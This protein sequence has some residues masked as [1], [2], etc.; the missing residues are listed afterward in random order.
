MPGRMFRSEGPIHY[1]QY[2]FGYC[3]WLELNEGEEVTGV[4]EGGYLPFSGRP[5]D[6]RCLFYMARSLRVDMRNVGLSKKRRYDHR[7][8]QSFG[9]AR[10]LQS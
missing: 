7:H 10:D 8:W 1:A 9:L 2:Q 3:E 4:Y 5:S 6:P